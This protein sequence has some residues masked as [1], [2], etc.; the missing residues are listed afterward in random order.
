MLGR[1]GGTESG[2]QACCFAKAGD[3]GVH[4]V[5]SAAPLLDPHVDDA[6]S[7]GAGT[8]KLSEEDGGA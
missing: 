6:V 3:L 7:G 1:I 4:V 8:E 2:D 5:E